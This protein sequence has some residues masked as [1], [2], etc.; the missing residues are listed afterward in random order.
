MDTVLSIYFHPP[1]NVGLNSGGLR[2]QCVRLL[3][4]S[5]WQGD[6]LAK[7]VFAEFSYPTLKPKSGKIPYLVDLIENPDAFKIY[8]NFNCDPLLSS[9]FDT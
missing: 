7:T 9:V 6:K 8:M 5:D 3:I 1:Q 2:K 4:S